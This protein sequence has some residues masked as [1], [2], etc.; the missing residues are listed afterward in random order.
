M[1]YRKLGN[2]GLEVSEI[3]FGGGNNG[4][5]LFRPPPAV[6]LEAVRHAL[7]LGINWFDSAP[8]YGDGQSE[9]NLG[10][11]LKEL[12]ATPH[13]STKVSI[14][15]G[16]LGDLKGGALRSAE[17]SL[18][19]LGRSAVDVLQIHHP[20]TM[21]RGTRRNSLSVEDVLGPGGVLDALQ[22]LKGQGHVRFFGFTGLGETEAIHALVCSGQFNT[23]QAYYNL[24]NPSAGEAVPSGFSAQDYRMLIPLAASQGMGVLAIRT[25]AG[26][27]LAGQAR[28]GGG[29]HTLSPGS[30]YDADLERAVKVRQ[31]LREETGTLPQTAMRYV[32]SHPSVSTV[33]VGFSSVEHID[34]AVRCAASP[35]LSPAS[36]A[37]LQRL[38]A[39]DF[40][41]D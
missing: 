11:A 41:G 9:E 8:A 22:E 26:G 38:Y 36:L 34:E 37:R 6:R 32:L 15:A 18:T 27:A 2:T 25:L 19:R 29:G 31:A 33:L 13:V 7:E 16:E 4:G 10:W 28:G 40:A 14:P 3:A 21:R 30:E 35:G 20:I 12:G 24:L 1:R 5:I 39:R 17:R 23:I